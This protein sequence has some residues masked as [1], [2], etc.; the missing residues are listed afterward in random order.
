MTAPRAL[1]GIKVLDLSRVLAGPW[2]TQCLA[3]LGADVLKIENPDGGDETRSWASPPM[4]GMAAYYTSANRSKRSLAVDLKSQEGRALVLRLAAVAD[5][6][7]ENFKLGDLD[8][9]GLGYAQLRAVNPRLVYCSI[10][11]YGRSGPDAARAGYDFVI[12]AESGLMSITGEPGGAPMK[13]GVAV[14]DLFTGLYASQ[15]ILAALVE[16]GRTGQGRHLDVSL[17]DCQIA[18]LA[19]MAASA[20]AN[21]KQPGRYGNAHASI[22]PYE[23]F[24]TADKPMVIAVGNDRQFRKLTDVLGAAQLAAD[25]RFAT[26]KLRVEH[27][28]ELVAAVT[29]R[30][31]TA[32]CERWLPALHAAGIPAGAIRSIVETLQ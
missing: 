32:P 7:V 9:L 30:L 11:G 14:S 18:A 4:A 21:G 12:Q 16:R 1:S 29:A 22:V 25:P 15:A 24:E 23:L 28:A 13:V 20:L 26:N 3:D 27:R 17:H 19:N 10:S 6:L 8:R 5:V 31:K 2:C